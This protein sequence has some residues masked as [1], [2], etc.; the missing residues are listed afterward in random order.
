MKDD[1]ILN[2]RAHSFKAGEQLHTTSVR[3]IFPKHHLPG[4]KGKQKEAQAGRQAGKQGRQGLGKKDTPS[5][6]GKQ[7]ERQA[8]RQ[9]GRQDGRQVGDKADEALGMGTHHPT[10]GN[11]KGEK[12]GDKRGDKLRNKL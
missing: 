5:N 10:K 2:P 12:L 9:E 3:S 4:H 8:G 6:K 7:K 11:K 1:I